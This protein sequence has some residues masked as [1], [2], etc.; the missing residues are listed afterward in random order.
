MTIQEKVTNL[1]KNLN[2]K[3]PEG[4]QAFAA[5]SAVL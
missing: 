2:E 1:F 4:I 3:Y 5:S